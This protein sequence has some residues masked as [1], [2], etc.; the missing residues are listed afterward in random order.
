[1]IQNGIEKV[2]KI[3][4]YISDIHWSHASPPTPVDEDGKIK[5]I[6]SPNSDIN[7]FELFNFFKSSFDALDRLY[8][9][10]QPR[11]V[12]AVLNNS[13]QTGHL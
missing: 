1:M 6:S 3:V 4:L 7:I 9:P 13:F 2:S 10:D 11:A 8:R 5:N 12:E